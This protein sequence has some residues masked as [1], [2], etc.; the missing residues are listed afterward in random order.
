MKI[1][2]SLLFLY[3]FLAFGQQVTV[4]WDK[5]PVSF[6]TWYVVCVSDTVNSPCLSFSWFQFLKVT[7]IST[8]L[9]YQFDETQLQRPIG[10]KY[11]IRVAAVQNGNW[12]Y[13]DWTY[14]VCTTYT[15]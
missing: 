1:F 3:P 4:T 9:Q 15:Q 13:G 12:P 11:C 6:S 2:L 14:P 5:P 7:G 10:S 8:S